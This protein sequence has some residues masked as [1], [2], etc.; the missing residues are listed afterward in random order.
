[1]PDVESS[2]SSAATAEYTDEKHVAL[3]K[4]AGH[5]EKLI[6][7]KATRKSVDRRALRCLSPR[8]G[9]PERRKRLQPQLSR[10]AVEREPVDLS[11]GEG[12]FPWPPSRRIR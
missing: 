9:E 8:F 10:Q 11:R 2:L 4:W 3:D 12:T 1:M 5:V 6:G 7:N